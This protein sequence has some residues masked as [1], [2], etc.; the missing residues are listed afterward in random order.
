ME[1]I[2]KE[3]IKEAK[4]GNMGAFE[5]LIIRYESKVY[6][7]AY[8]MFNNEEDA[9]DVSQEIF[10]KL[11]RNLIKFNEQSKF[12]TWLYRVAVNTCLD[13]IRKRKK[14]KENLTSNVYETEDG[15]IE[16]EIPSTYNMPEAEL[17][18]NDRIEKLR[19][20]LTLI[21]EDHR[22]VI[23]LKDLEGYSYNE[24]ADT[25]NITI[26]TV[27]SRISRARES[28][29]ETLEQIDSDLRQ[30]TREEGM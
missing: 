20:A 26:G 3:L 23:V 7:I 1:G 25:L 6:N 10:I 17:I 2:E 27:K 4:L 13:E 15:E 16:R 22:S 21:K 9:K 8:K 28:L 24:I 18:K 14:D 19:Y 11:Y 5:S 12:S 30:N 29:K